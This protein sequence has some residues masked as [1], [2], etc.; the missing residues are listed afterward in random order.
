MEHICCSFI[1]PWERWHWQILNDS[2]MGHFTT[3]QFVIWSRYSFSRWSAYH[4]STC[5]FDQKERFSWNFILLFAVL[6][7]VHAKRSILDFTFVNLVSIMRELQHQCSQYRERDF[8]YR[9]TLSAFYTTFL[10]MR[11]IEKVKTA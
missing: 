8:A 3:N 6:Q 10:L 1:S 9:C 5:S 7:E 2:S 11:K 4:S